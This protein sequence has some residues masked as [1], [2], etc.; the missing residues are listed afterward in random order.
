MLINFLILYANIFS[1]S[2]NIINNSKWEL[3]KDENSIKV[4]LRKND[5][6]VSEYLAVT[7]VN[8]DINSILNFILD[9]D[10]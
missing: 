2:E 9:F 10:N 6:N 8:S 3:R 7:E 5:N 4:Y 1:F